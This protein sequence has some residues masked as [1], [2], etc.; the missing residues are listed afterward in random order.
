LSLPKTMVVP[1]DSTDSTPTPKK[2]KKN[3][4]TKFSNFH[5]STA[6]RPDIRSVFRQLSA[7]KL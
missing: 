4:S 3:S 2:G 1:N 6:R 7:N 5:I